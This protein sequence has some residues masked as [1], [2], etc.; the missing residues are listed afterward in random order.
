MLMLQPKAKRLSIE[1]VVDHAQPT[2]CL[3]F[4]SP[5]LSVGVQKV[6]EG[7]ISRFI[8]GTPVRQ[9]DSSV[10]LRAVKK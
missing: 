7:K 9:Q 4:S 5:P 2:K 6:K 8:M 3:H 1:T 10:Y